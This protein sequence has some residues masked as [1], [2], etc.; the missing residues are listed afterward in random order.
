MEATKRLAAITN[1]TQACAALGVARASAFRFWQRKDHPIPPKAPVTPERS[2]S[3]AEKEHVLL[4]LHSERFVDLA[5][6]EVYATLLDEGVYLCSIRTMYRI[7]AD[8]AEVRERRHQAAHVAY[9]KP[10]LLATRPNELWSWDITKLKG[11][12]KWSYF[13]LY[14]IIDV[15][16]RYVVGWMVAD[17]ESS[18]LATRLIAETIR[19]QEAAP[20]SLTIHA[21]RGSSMK[22][23]CVALMLSDLGVTKTHSRPHVSNDNPFSESQFKTMKYRPEFP[24]R[25]GSIEDARAFCVKFFEWYNTEHHHAGIA[26]HTPETVHYG[27]AESITLKRTVTLQEAYQRHPERF[28]RKQP[29]PPRLP[30]AVWINPPATV[31]NTQE[32]LTN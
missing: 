24:A 23:K 22:S 2:L 16:S 1:W 5:P 29:E 12:V 28:V 8:N 18:A 14:V 17:R 3:T 30:T 13:Q 26:L 25:F 6:Q 11:A 15:F 7:L 31:G 27:L 21:D 19:K 20:R 9:A 4:V 32:L 10:E